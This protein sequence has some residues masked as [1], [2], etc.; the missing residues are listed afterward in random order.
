MPVPRR[1]AVAVVHWRCSKLPAL[2]ADLAVARLI[3][4]R[5]R[6]GRKRVAWLAAMA[7]ANPALL[8]NS[9]SGARPTR[10]WHCSP[11]LA[12]LALGDRRFRARVEPRGARDPDQAAGVAARAAVRALAVGLVEERTSAVAAARDP[13]DGVRRRRPVP[14]RASWTWLVELYTGTTGYAE[15]SVNAMNLPA[16]LFGM[17]GN[18]P[19]AISA[20]AHERW[21]SRS[22]SSSA[23]SSRA[24]TCGG[25]RCTGLVAAA[26]P[27]RVRSLTR[28]H[29]R[30]LYPYF[31]VR[32]P[33]Q[34]HRTVGRPVLG[35]VGAVLRQRTAG[36]PLP[37]DRR[38]RRSVWL[39]KTLSVLG[40][41]CVPVAAGCT[42]GSPDGRTTRRAR[43]RSTRT[44]RALAAVAR[45]RAGGRGYARTGGTSGDGSTP[46]R[47][48]MRR[49]AGTKSRSF[50][51][52]D[53]GVART[54]P[55]RPRQSDRPGV[56]RGSTSSRAGPG[57]P[58]RQGLHGPASADREADVGLGIKL[59]GDTP[60]GWRT[61]NAIVGT[62]CAAHVPARPRA[63]SAA[64]SPAAFAAFFV[65]FDGLCLV[66]SRIAVID[67][68]YVTWGVAGYVSA[69]YGP[70]TG[71]GANVAP[72]PDRRPLMGLSRRGEAY[73]LLQLPA[74][75]RHDR[76]HGVGLRQTARHRAAALRAVAGVRRPGS[77]RAWCTCCP[78]A[79]TS[80][81]AGG[82]AARPRQITSCSVPG[83]GRGEGHRR[84]R[85]ARSGGR[86][87]CCCVRSGT[88][89]GSRTGARHGRRHLG[90]RQSA[91]VVGGAARR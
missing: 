24:I 60:T 42:G 62:R 5:L 79:P 10:S 15:T 25:A 86:G 7:F 72:A 52:A 58:R 41:A 81:G 16:L 71:W 78:Y 88:T 47:H 27:G 74:R 11:L 51:I 82:L 20:S 89:G 1:M 2:L 9:P 91:G 36:L 4:A 22:G 80:G 49:G 54:A 13:R 33:D 66:D 85:T 26:T 46:T 34:R 63:V 75:A 6:P 31:I 12:F 8:L 65:A 40:V 29:E 55:A 77:S 61:M 30:H 76:A 59:F 57:L 17:R 70:Q 48:R 83:P 23:W 35:A 3:F 90:L 28:M 45:D 18:D 19:S 14:R 68:H 39:W 44:M 56:R 67:I 38:D 37:P 64:A 21:A 32:R 43:R 73:I 53:R 69:L 87:R 84:T 50:F